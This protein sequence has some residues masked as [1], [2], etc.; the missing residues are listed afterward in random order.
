MCRP[1]TTVRFVNSGSDDKT[2]DLSKLNDSKLKASITTYEVNAKNKTIFKSEKTADITVKM[3]N[4][5]VKS[6]LDV[7]AAA[8]NSKVNYMTLEIE[9]LNVEAAVTFSD[10]VDNTKAILKGTNVTVEAGGSVA[11]GKFNRSE[12]ATLLVNANEG[13]K[14]AGAIT[15]NFSSQ[16]LISKN[17]TVNGTADILQATGSTST[18]VAGDVWLLEGATS[19]GDGNWLHGIPTPWAN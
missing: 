16:T 11:M 5:I 15:F 4:L 7:T 19:V 6:A 10:V 18:D 14:N 13:Q 9:D 3:K 8:T 2:Y 17:I 12:I 1:T